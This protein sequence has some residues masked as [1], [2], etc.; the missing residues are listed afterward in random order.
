MEAYVF[1]F[2][3]LILL[4]V[5]YYLVRRKQAFISECDQVD[6]VVIRFRESRRPGKNTTYAPVVEYFAYGKSYQHESS[7]YRAGPGFE[8]NQ[9]V[10][11]LYKR[12]KP[13]DAIIDNFLEKW[14]IPM[15][16]GIIGA[17]FLIIGFIFPL[18]VREF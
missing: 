2:V 5:A 16:F 14:F 18:L 6:G 12:D 9:T 8:I 15:I 10:T 11:I 13:E 17:V 4:G 7:L 1:Q 3:S